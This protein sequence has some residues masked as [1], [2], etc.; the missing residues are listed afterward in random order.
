MKRIRGLSRAPSGLADYRE[1]K[2]ERGGWEAF[3]SHRGGAAHRELLDALAARQRGL[4]GYCE[5]NLAPTDRQ[6]EHVVPQSD[7]KVGEALALEASNLIACCKGGTK[8]GGNG[9]RRT[10]PV[11]L[12]R[13]CGEAKGA[14]S[15]PDFLDPRTVPAL[16]SI[17]RVEPS[18]LI[19]ADPE[20][21]AEAGFEVVPVER[22]IR[23]LGLNVGRLQ[24][25]R[26][27]RWNSLDAVWASDRENMECMA[28]A[29]RS[30]L[31]MRD[32][33]I[34]PYFTTVRSYFGSAAEEV[35]SET[36]EDWV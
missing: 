15:D 33:G 29:A 13:S 11:R 34:P 10:D 27:E 7:P 18:G 14:I 26:L 36:P 32:G 6:V 23:I 25:A 2:S 30:E 35:L 21:C 8:A 3:R 5:I 31:L 4:C 17:T 20:A 12:N 19:V 22:T 16:P 28:K 1:T 24:G 9:E